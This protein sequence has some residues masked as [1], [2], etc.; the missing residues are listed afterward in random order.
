MPHLAS[1]LNRVENIFLSKMAYGEA[2]LSRRIGDNQQP[3]VFVD[4]EM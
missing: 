2:L 4:E 1:N 3:L